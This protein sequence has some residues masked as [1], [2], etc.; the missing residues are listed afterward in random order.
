MERESIAFRV[1]R[2]DGSGNRGKIPGELQDRPA[3]ANPQA[4]GKTRSRCAVLKR[5]GA[6]LGHKEG[7]K[8]I[9]DPQVRAMI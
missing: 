6:I 4:G 9:A 7:T 2:D 8:W 3:P 1:E 5:V